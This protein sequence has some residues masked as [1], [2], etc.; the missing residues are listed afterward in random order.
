[1]SGAG[2][3]DSAP[4]TPAWHTL[5]PAVA[6]DALQ[7]VATGLDE[8]QARLRLERIGPNRLREP[9]R[10]GRLR[11]FLAQF[12]N[13]L[14]GVLLAAALVTALLDHWTDTAVIVAVAL[15]NAIIGMIQEGRAENA[16]AAIR[17]MLAPG[18]TVLR[19]GL[20]RHIEA[21]QLVPG[22]V[23]W[24]EAGDL[25]PAD[26][27]LL[28]NHGAEVDEAILTG[29]SVPVAKQTA[30]VPDGASLGDRRCMAYSGTLVTT[31]QCTGV[32]VATGDATELGRISG[33][34]AMVGTLE[35]P[36]V[37]QMDRFA[38]R[39]TAIIV[40]TG[41]ALLAYG[42]WLRGMPFGEMFMVVVGLMV[43]AIPEGLP[44]VLT[45]TLAIGVQAMAAR[46]AIVRRL[47]A[48]ETVGAVSVICSD[49]TGTLTRNE[50]SVV[51]VVLAERTYHPENAGYAPCGELTGDGSQG[52]KQPPTALDTL[53]R[54]AGLC[55]DARLRHDATGWHVEGDPMEGALLALAGKAGWDATR[56]RRDWVR[57]DV[58]AFDA[59][60]RFMATL[61]HDPHGQGLIA[62]KGAPE[63]ILQMCNGQSDLAGQPAPM[64]AADWLQAAE[65][66]AAEGHR[67]LALAFRNTSSH[68]RRLHQE[69]I[70]GRLILL[71]LVAL[72]DPPR[73]GVA[74]AVAECRAAG[75][76]V[77]MITGDHAATALAIAGRIGLDTCGGV[78]TG[79][80]L[81]RLDASELA[82]AALRVNVFARTSP[83]HKLQLVGAL[84]AHGLAVAMTGDGVNDAPALKLADAGIAMGR[85]GSAAAREAADLVL[86]DDD[87]TSIVA[88]VREGR[89]VYA[90]LRKVIS[91][92][93]PTNAGE[94]MTIIAAILAGLALPVTPLQI[95][96]VNLITAVTL[97]VAL[98]FEP[99]DRDAMRQ[100]PRCR[101]EPLVGPDL[102]WHITLVA[103]LF[104]TGVF[105]I[106]SWAAERG[107]SVEQARTL[108]LI[109]LVAMEIFHLLFIRNLDRPAIGLDDLRG[110]PAV[111]LSI[112]LV[113][114]AQIAVTWFTPLQEVFGTAPAGPLETLAALGTGPALFVLLEAEKRVRLSLM[115]APSKAGPPLA[116]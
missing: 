1:M 38:R 9:P 28:E 64:V 57:S 48:I 45:I 55:N 74:D 7:S 92:T 63:R 34:L 109:T 96:W 106:Y 53:A 60:H 104:V 113:V 13:L 70:D 40:L 72:I 98:A 79:A 73:P 116:S 33:M 69:D 62:V 84:Q 44:A 15:I 108:A 52:E 20:R 76:G 103:G 46:N 83:E 31:G 12:D 30:A 77:K 51:R 97:G 29:E 81:D 35:T 95:L 21:E 58:I 36:L 110:S 86:A 112:G 91:W 68:H 78:L 93:L 49:K 18:A 27:R 99:T 24:L 50:M 87:F 94:A 114:A 16:L 59:R 89:T 11:R 82:A 32:V 26:L 25:V 22:D 66:L 115:R 71:G 10:P 43:A 111:W 37:A 56:L 23:V 41:V 2:G 54:V 39:L 65:A 42:H 75:I 17:R 19:S 88:A 67:V 61:D 101:N 105:G 5:A 6:L 14:I 47:P 85:K 8:H 100:P 3:H 107:A 4:A 90:N 80:D 102:L